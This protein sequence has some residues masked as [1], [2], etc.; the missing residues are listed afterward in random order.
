MHAFGS[1]LAARAAPW[2]VLLSLGLCREAR[3]ETE[4]RESS[5][6]ISEEWAM[7]RELR[8]ANL[9]HGEQDLD[10]D[11]IPAEADLSSLILRSRRVPL[12]VLSLERAETGHDVVHCRIRSPVEAARAGLDIMYRM[13]GLRWEAVYEIVVRGEGEDERE[14][15]SC[16]LRGMIRIVNA[17]TRTFSNTLVRIEQLEQSGDAERMSGPGFLVLDRADPLS[18]LWFDRAGEPA[19]PYQF[20]IPRRVN[21]AAHSETEVPLIVRVRTPAWRFYEMVAEEVPTGRREPMPLRKYISFRHEDERDEKAAMLPA[22]RVRVYAGARRR[23]FVQEARFQR[24]LRGGEIRVDLGL[25][26]D[27][28]AWR[29]AGPRVKLPG[30]G[31]GESSEIRIRN[32]G[33]TDVRVEVDEKP[34]TT[35]G[36]SLISS[37]MPCREVSNRLRFSLTLGAGSEERIG[38]E[39]RLRE[40][41]I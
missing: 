4:L 23:H 34:A 2:L 40:P 1:S 20:N 30:G 37:T 14:P 8:R 28:K 41:E 29:V 13:R 22:G 15:V 10:L 33:D 6:T 26:D 17:T 38:Y 21:M 19:I 36:W 3:A 39:F 12:E 18:D 11:R 31:M 32:E 35:L 5:V 16:D 9:L 7:V 24:T 27:V 25:S